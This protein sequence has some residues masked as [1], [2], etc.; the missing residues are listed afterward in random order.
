MNNQAKMIIITSNED[1]IEQ[2]SLN[3]SENTRI[4]DL[5]QNKINSSMIIKD[6]NHSID[7]NLLAQLSELVCI[8]FICFF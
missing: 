1:L 3:Q 4:I 5:N 6:N 7:L 2:I 8:S